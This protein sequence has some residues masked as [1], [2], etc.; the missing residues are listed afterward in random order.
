MTTKDSKYTKSVGL[1]IKLARVKAGLTQE[2]LAEKADL[3]R[4][5]IGD[6]ERGIKSP[7]VATVGAIADALG[8][9][10]YKLF[11]FD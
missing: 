7:T 11:I 6:T 10:M 3:S 4:E 8:I 9:D 2:A 1:N 5:T